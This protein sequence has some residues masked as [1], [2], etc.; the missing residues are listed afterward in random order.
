MKAVAE[1]S[2]FV[3]PDS[4]I[5]TFGLTAILF[6]LSVYYTSIILSYLIRSKLFKTFPQ[7]RYAWNTAFNILSKSHKA[8]AYYLRQI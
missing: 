7:G 8:G 6:F 3:S 4:T 2:Q 5:S 1:K